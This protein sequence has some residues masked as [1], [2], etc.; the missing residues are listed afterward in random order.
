MGAAPA[1]SR[2]S[3]RSVSAPAP[4]IQ[5]ARGPRID[6]MPGKGASSQPK[7][8]SSSVLFLAKTVAVLLLV[9]AALGI[10]RIALTSAAVST[11]LENQELSSQI[12]SARKEG[13]QLEVA[14]SSLSN[15]A[16]VKAEAGALGMTDPVITYTLSLE[17][18]VVATDAAG[19]LSLS[20][21]VRLA[22]GA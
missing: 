5:P 12:N 21:S 9:V 1:Y 8:L 10:A 13:N 20:E 17:Q 15:P 19:N 4:R 11:T 7:P 2:Y 3:A 22:A 14:Q 18:D 16:R 6:V